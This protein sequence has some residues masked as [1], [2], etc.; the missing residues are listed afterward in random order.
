LRHGVSA[1]SPGLRNVT[2]AF[3]MCS[4][5]ILHAAMA[6]QT[7]SGGLVMLQS[8]QDRKPMHVLPCR[9]EIFLTGQRRGPNAEIPGKLFQVSCLF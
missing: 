5:V 9:C 2:K 8:L 1:M 6:A 7:E 4:P 3:H